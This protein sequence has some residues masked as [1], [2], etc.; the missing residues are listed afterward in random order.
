MTFLVNFF[1]SY[2]YTFVNMRALFISQVENVQLKLFLFMVLL[3]GIWKVGIIMKVGI[4]IKG[5]MIFTF[6]QINFNDDQ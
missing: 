4:I 5:D 6:A 3:L 1:K 2:N